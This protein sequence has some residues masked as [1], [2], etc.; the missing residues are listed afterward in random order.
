MSEPFTDPTPTQAECASLSRATL[1]L[2]MHALDAE[3]GRATALEQGVLT[4]CDGDLTAIAYRRA[5]T[6]RRNIED[7]RHEVIRAV[8]ALLDDGEY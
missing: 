1:L 8:E 3:R 4:L 2:C 6:R 7:A 5:A